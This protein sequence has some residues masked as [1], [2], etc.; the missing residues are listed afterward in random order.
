MSETSSRY[1]DDDIFQNFEHESLDVEEE[2]QKMNEKYETIERVGGRRNV[3]RVIGG[4]SGLGEEEDLMMFL[5]QVKEENEHL[6]GQLHE[7]MSKRGSGGESELKKLENKVHVLRKRYDEQRHEVRVLE[8]EIHK[9]EEFLQTVRDPMGQKQQ[10]SS[11]LATKEKA[12]RVLEN[13]LDKTIIKYNESQMIQSTYRELLKR[14]KRERMGFDHQLRSIEKTLKSKS[15]DFDNLRQKYHEAT[16]L[17]ELSKNRLKE[18]REELKSLRRTKAKELEEKKRDVLSR[19][20][21]TE[22]LTQREVKRRQN[23]GSASS[24]TSKEQVVARMGDLGDE[25]GLRRTEED[26]GNLEEIWRRLKEVTGT[27]NS[28]GVIKKFRSAESTFSSLKEATSK[29]QERIETLTTKRNDLKEKLEGLKYSQGN[30]AGMGT[31]RMVDEFLQQLSDARALLGKHQR[32]YEHMQ[33]ILVRV[34]TGLTHLVGKMAVLVGEKETEETDGLSERDLIVGLI[35]RMDRLLREKMGVD[36][37]VQKMEKSE[38]EKEEKGEEEKEK[39]RDDD[40]DDDDD[41][42]FQLSKYNVRLNGIL[43]KKGKLR[44]DDDMDNEEESDSGSD[45]GSDGSSYITGEE[46]VADV[47]DRAQLKFLTQLAVE[48]HKSKQKKR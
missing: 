3:S 5:K 10:Q 42:I 38:Q 22:K 11:S 33:D 39:K 46:D 8:K 23:K 48:K 19:I 37:L 2:I 24:P 14:L 30:L 40:D 1:S 7:L 4:A 15:N 27:G 13:R 29:S 43:K 17:K 41:D 36:E 12:I 31:K 20:R 26:L 28:K 18:A 32:E 9:K 47:L 25:A 21:L 6:K 44:D 45:E 34:K 16:Y 35:E